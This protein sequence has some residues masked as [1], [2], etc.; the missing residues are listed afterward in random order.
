MEEYFFLVVPNWFCSTEEANDDT[1]IVLCSFGN[2]PSN[3]PVIPECLRNV[4]HLYQLPDCLV[5]VDLVMLLEASSLTL[6]MISSR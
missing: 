2:P 5:A 4:H 3:S 1:R 6:D